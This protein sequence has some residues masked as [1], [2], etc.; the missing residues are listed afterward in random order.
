MIIFIAYKRKRENYAFAYRNSLLSH[1]SIILKGKSVIE[2]FEKAYRK[3][4]GE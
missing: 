4:T 2:Q 1:F 3:L